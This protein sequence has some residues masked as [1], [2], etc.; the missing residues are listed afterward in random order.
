MIGIGGD[1]F[2]S[3]TEDQQPH[4]L[5]SVVKRFD[6]A[7]YDFI[8]SV[9]EG[10]PLTGRHT[11]GIDEDGLNIVT[12]GGFLTKRNLAVIE[13]FKDRVESGNIE[14]PDSLN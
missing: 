6:T 12:S 10:D 3:A 9:D 7:T 2:Q 8:E 1:Q 14:V 11:Y 4:I 5:T 13:G